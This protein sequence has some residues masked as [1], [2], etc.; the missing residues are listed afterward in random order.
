MRGL[1]GAGLAGAGLPGAGLP[2]AGLPGAGAGLGRLSSLPHPEVP[3]LMRIR[4]G[5]R[6]QL[7]E[8][9]IQGGAELEMPRWGMR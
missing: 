6:V 9:Q 2:S 1:P 8:Q 7:R 3:S 5:R 4:G